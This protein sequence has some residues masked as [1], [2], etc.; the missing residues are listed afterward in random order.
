MKSNHRSI[1]SGLNVSRHTA[2]AGEMRAAL[3]SPTAREDA[4]ATASMRGIESVESGGAS[5]RWGEDGG[6]GASGEGGGRRDDDP[7]GFERISISSRARGGRGRRGVD[8]RG[9]GVERD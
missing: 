3:A 5:E 7:P 1:E 2:R 4:R 9:G 8:A 6:L